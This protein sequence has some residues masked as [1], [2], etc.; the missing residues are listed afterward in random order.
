VLDAWY[1]PD[2]WER[3][4]TAPSFFKS[5]PDAIT[6]LVTKIVSS[7]AVFFPGFIMLFLFIRSMKAEIGPVVG[8]P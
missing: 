2:C 3:R 7:A 4:S 5:S 8:Q 6:M 1:T